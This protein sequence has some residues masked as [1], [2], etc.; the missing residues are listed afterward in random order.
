MNNKGTLIFG[1]IT[2]VISIIFAVLSRV[3]E[4]PEEQQKD[5]GVILFVNL[6]QDLLSSYIT[7]SSSSITILTRSHKLYNES[8]KTSLE[9]AQTKGVKLNIISDIDTNIT[10]YKFNNLT[11]AFRKSFPGGINS[12]FFIFDEK[13]V[14]IPTSTFPFYYGMPAIIIK[15]APAVVHDLNTFLKYGEDPNPSGVWSNELVV[16]HNFVNPHTY[17]NSVNLSFA[18]LGGPKIPPVRDTVLQIAKTVFQKSNGNSYISTSRFMQTTNGKPVFSFEN[19]IVAY[20]SKIEASNHS[21]D[22]LAKIDVN[23]TE[24]F[25]ETIRWLGAIQAARNI[26]VRISDASHISNF[27]I[28]GDTVLW[29]SF[30]FSDKAFANT[31]GIILIMRNN[32]E[33]NKQLSDYFI[34][35]FNTATHQNLANIPEFQELISKS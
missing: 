35:N 32:K 11:A 14:L 2:F 6:T 26:K 4:T 24:R 22:V 12:D 16:E 3:L 7:D 13:H 15:D 34:G 27:I 17:N 25:N 33:F 1:A 9:K 10:G 30:P 29:S 19:E 21:V 28:I 20:A 8:I 18:M 5:S 31:Y 23:N